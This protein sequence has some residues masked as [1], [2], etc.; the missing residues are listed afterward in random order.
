[1]TLVA[2]GRC[3]R[4]GTAHVQRLAPR[5]IALSH[6]QLAVPLPRRA[7]VDLHGST[8]LPLPAS[9][10]PTA[11]SITSP[12]A[13]AGAAVAPLDC[14]PE[15]SRQ[16]TALPA[17]RHYKE[18]QEQ[19]ETQEQ[20]P[21]PAWSPPPDRSGVLDAS[22][23]LL[24]KCLTLSELEEWFAAEG[25]AAPARRAL[26]LWRWMY[27]DPP[28]CSRSP[29]ADA[30]VGGLEETRGRQNGFSAAF[31]ERFGPQL[32][33]SGGLRLQRVVRAA[34]GTRKLQFE[35]THGS[36][37]GGAVEA[38]IIP[39]VRQQGRRDRLTLCV[40]SQVG[41]A[42]NCQFCFTGR[43]G[44]RGQL[45][46]G[47][48]VEQLVE[49]RRLL[50]EEGDRTPLT[51]L[52]FMGMGEPLHNP[53]AVTAAAAIA[54]HP[55]GLHISPNKIT[56]ST[57][58]LVPELRWL[59]A[60]SRVQVALSLHATTD[61]VRDW[62]V[63]VN[64]RYDLAC[65]TATLQELFPKTQQP[66]QQQPEQQQQLPQQPTTTSPLAVASKDE[67][68]GENGNRAGA[69]ASGGGEGGDVHVQQQGQ[70]R[71]AG[72]SSCSGPQQGDAEEVQGVEVEEDE[73]SADRWLP[74]LGPRG[75]GG[76][77]SSSSS[78]GGGGGSSGVAAATAAVAAVA[79]PDAADSS[80]C[81]SDSSSNTTSPAAAD[82]VDTAAS[83]NSA[84]STG[85]CGCGSTGSS[86]VVGSSSS[87]GPSSDISGG[88]SSSSSSSSDSI[89]GGQSPRSLLVGYTLLHG[90]ND[91]LEDAERLASMLSRVQCKVNL[92]VFNPHEGTRFQPSR[93]EDVTAFRSHLISRGLVCTIRDS[94]GDDE[95]AACG[96]L[97]DVGPALRPAPILEPPERFRRFL[98]P[99][100]APQRTPAEG[101][102]QQQ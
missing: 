44:L 32:S 66:Q 24:A 17:G 59:V 93:P 94:R 7:L 27:A 33:L 85:A 82:A 41:C 83:A 49:A 100:P 42:M 61:E 18:P 11:A 70:Q 96:Q 28:A 16:H 67:G 87:S 30:W 8:G 43:M 88:S 29:A 3:P 34:D 19:K 10:A 75:F 65:L 38:V 84:A 89:G 48:I 62:I 79:E 35:V 71:H 53:H 15:Q 12:A 40:S 74:P 5:E 90:I 6:A 9:T 56:V 99:P 21:R 58:G 39:V 37:A 81:G 102:Q 1:M 51:N 98:L 80:Q 23:R 101:K 69:G 2:G 31:L 57:V 22:G 55:L 46:A 91:T 4:L 92:I 13:A 47:Q 86:H 76:D 26:Q 77:D 68:E 95:M 52:V 64:R 54:S 45:S 25:E 97:G 20:A 14:V 60:H 78:R 73:L 36:A 50:A 72:P 63:P